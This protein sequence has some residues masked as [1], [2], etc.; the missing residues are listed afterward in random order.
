M[1]FPVLLRSGDPARTPEWFDGIKTL[2]DLRAA[3]EDGPRTIDVEQSPHF[4]R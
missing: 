2:D 3:V 4:E 1:T